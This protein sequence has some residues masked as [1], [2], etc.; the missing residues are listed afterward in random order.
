MD[1]SKLP[2]PVSILGQSRKITALRAL[3]PIDAGLQLD[4]LCIGSRD[5]TQVFRQR[6]QTQVVAPT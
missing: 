6:I 1:I 4:I 3:K 2:M 5:T